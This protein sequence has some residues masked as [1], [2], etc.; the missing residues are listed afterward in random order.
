VILCKKYGNKALAG[1]VNGVLRNIV[2]HKND[3]QF[4]PKESDPVLNLSLTYSY[5]TWLVEK[6]IRDYGLNTAESMLMPVQNEEYITVRVNKNRITK[7]GLKAQLAQQGIGCADGLYMNDEALRIY[8][9]LDVEHNQLYREGFFTVQGESSMLVT[10]VLDPK[11]GESIIDACSAPGGKATHVAERMGND[12]RILAWDVHPQRVD[13]V[14]FNARRLGAVIVEPKQQDAGEFQ[15]DLEGQI[16]RVLIDAPCSGWGVIHKKPDIK[17]NIKQMELNDLYNI[18]T[19]IIST[20]CRYVKPG[21]VLVY[22]TC[23][24][25]IDEN[26]LLIERFLGHNHDFFLDDFTDLLPIGLKSS[27]I[28]PGMIQLIPSRDGIDGFFIARL[29][30]MM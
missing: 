13:L 4:P 2:R 16:D 18:Q 23:T 11:R 22:S 29:R 10:H 28:R 9:A 30:R 6:W 8:S 25:N 20:C 3:I 14:K 27:I 17:N 5:P 21:G 12:G 15:A 1:F 7:E 19:Q 24:M 26:Q